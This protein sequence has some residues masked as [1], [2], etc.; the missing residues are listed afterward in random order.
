M[1]V[2]SVYSRFGWIGKDREKEEKKH[3]QYIY[4]LLAFINQKEKEKGMKIT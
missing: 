3:R 4:L 2:L 1:F